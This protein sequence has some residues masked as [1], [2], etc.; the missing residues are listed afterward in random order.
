MSFDY[1]GL[2][3]DGELALKQGEAMRQTRSNYESIWS[4]ISENMFPMKAMYTGKYPGKRLGYSMYDSTPQTCVSILAAQIA[5]ALT[6]AHEPF[7]MYEPYD[8]KIRDNW[9]VKT[10]C[11]HRE[12]VM[13]EVLASSNFQSQI[14]QVFLDEVLFGNGIIYTEEHPEFVVNFSSRDLSEIFFD[15]DQ[16][17]YV[18]SVARYY[19]CSI[20]T[21]VQEFGLENCPQE[22][23][24]KYL[25]PDYQ[26]ETREVMHLVRPN[27][28][29]EPGKIGASGFKYESIYVDVTSKE[30]LE[31]SGYHEFPYAVGRWFVV[32]GEVYGRGPAENVLPDA[33]NLHVMNRHYVRAVQKATDPALLLPQKAFLGTKL[34]L[35]PGKLNFYRATGA[36]GGPKEL[37]GTFPGGDRAFPA[38]AQD[39]QRL[40]DDLKRGLFVD[41]VQ[42]VE[43]DRMT[44]AEVIQRTEENYRVL[45]PILGRNNTETLSPILDRVE[46]ICE[47][48]GMFL[49]MP[50][51]L[52]RAGGLKRAF[53]SPL[54]KAQR[55]QSAQGFVSAMDVVTPLVQIDPTLMEVMKRDKTFRYIFDNFGAPADLL[56]SPEE[57][58]ARMEEKAKK[59]AAMQEAQM[60]LES[61]QAMAGATAD[62]AKATKD[63]GGIERVGAM[64]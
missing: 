2:I 26:R 60:G 57:T 34:N 3:S 39:I 63:L 28:F 58:K 5:A 53:K 42:L 7:F 14:L 48:R 45:G 20:R 62:I 8:T 24:D 18:D 16:F 6:P 10:Y 43:K 37:V 19:T 35:G 47:R 41:K 15:V 32:S 29:Y 13:W 17:G 21:M 55:M 46:A 64:M 4:D 50:E 22:V 54:V 36:A 9:Q 27:A 12:A 33:R 40:R 38:S 11:Q 23:R 51:I 61:A 59:E 56:E 44:R 25:N 49:P 1:L 31:Q 52:K 30:P